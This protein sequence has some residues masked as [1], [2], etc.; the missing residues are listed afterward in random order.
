M[1]WSE[2]RIGDLIRVNQ[3]E[4]IP[5]DLLI[6]KTADPKGNAFV[7]TKNLDG[8]TNLK[9]KNLHKDMKYL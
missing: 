5:A 6:V 7:E 1:I 2:L 8:E 4:P 9:N 3:N